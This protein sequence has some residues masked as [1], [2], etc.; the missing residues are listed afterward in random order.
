MDRRLFVD[1]QKS[2]SSV[3]P[4]VRRIDGHS[5]W[6]RIA[7]Q[8]A[9]KGGEYTGEEFRQNCLETSIIQEFTATNTAQK[10]ELSERVGRTLCTIVQYMFADGGFPSSM[11][12]ELFMAAAYLKNRTLYK[13]LKMETSFKILHGEKADISHFRIIG[14]R[15]FVHIKDFR[16]L[17]AAAWEWKV[18]DYSEESKSYG[19]LNPK[20]HRV[21]ESRNVTFIETPSHLLPPP[22]KISPLQDL[23]PPSWDIDDD[24]LDNDYISYDDLLRDVRDYADVLDF[25]ANVPANHGNA[26]GVS[27]DPQV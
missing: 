5:L 11:W 7:R 26:S 23:V 4:T 12:G 1:Q 10:I 2:S 25:T 19:V 17:D 8:R 14:A 3:A 22:S 21:V 24:T 6:Q 16:K 9:D 18:C 20:T 27:V 15:T 13:A